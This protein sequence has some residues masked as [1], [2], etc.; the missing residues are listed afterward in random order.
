[1]SPRRLHPIL[2][3][4]ALTVVLG[5]CDLNP[6]DS[7]PSPATATAMP[8]A[9]PD[10]N[11]TPSATPPASATPVAFRPAPGPSFTRWKRIEAGDPLPAHRAYRLATDELWGLVR[12]DGVE[13][14]FGGGPFLFLVPDAETSMLLGTAAEH[15]PAGEM[16]TVDL[17]TGEVTQVLPFGVNRAVWRAPGVVWFVLDHPVRR[18][19]EVL[20]PPGAWL[21]DLA[22]SS[23]TPEVG[24]TDTARFSLPEPL[25]DATYH[26]GATAVLVRPQGLVDRF[27]V[28]LV[29]EPAGSE[30]VMDEFVQRD[31]WILAPDGAWLAY[32]T[33]QNE[34]RVMDFRSGEVRPL[35]VSVPRGRPMWSPDSRYLADAY[36]WYE[37]YQAV[38]FDVPAAFEVPPGSPLPR[39]GPIEGGWPLEW[40]PSEPRLLM[41]GDFCLPDGT[42]LD[43]LD[44]TTGEVRRLKPDIAGA[45]AVRWSP[46][47]TM[48]AVAAPGLP[49]A[50]IDAAGSVLPTP[51]LDRVDDLQIFSWMAGGAWLVLGEMPGRGRCY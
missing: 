10:A 18:D 33:A 3:S 48:I 13:M 29:D 37:G 2:L 31:S 5:A 17:A 40:H 4:V 35:G 7:T 46:D 14:F 49:I 47:G 12:D 22:A 32:V 43:L 6:P 28:V 23:L 20:L 44:A 24:P 9:S 26:P 16:V 8:G 36:Q 1:M 51:A 50:L 45:W 39:I 42:W 25:P 27:S 38:V 21:L 41:F 11:G 19:G 34:L 15:E 30:R